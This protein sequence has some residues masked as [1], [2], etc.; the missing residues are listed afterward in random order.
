MSGWDGTEELKLLLKEGIVQRERTPVGVML[1]AVYEHLIGVSLRRV[2]DAISHLCQ[3]SQAAVHHWVQKMEAFLREA[4]AL[5][6]GDLP[7][8][9][10]AYET[11]LH[12]GRRVVCLWVA[13]DPATRAVYHLAL[14]EARNILPA[15]SFPPESGRGTDAC[16]CGS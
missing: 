10:V 6:N 12:V 8:V 1:W 15:R 4:L 5:I 16:R 11:E 3:R 9:L 13:L 14:T 2:R 7:D